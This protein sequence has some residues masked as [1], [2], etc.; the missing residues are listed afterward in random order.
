M[1]TTLAR[2]PEEFRHMERWLSQEPPRARHRVRLDRPD[3]D[4][5]RSTRISCIGFGHTLCT[6]AK[7]EKRLGDDAR[8]SGRAP[9]FVC[10]YFQA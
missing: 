6:V 1:S 5:Y 3:Q 9:C 10:R 7:E 8:P 2:K 4:S